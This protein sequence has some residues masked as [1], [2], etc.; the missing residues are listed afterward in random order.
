MQINSIQ[1]GFWDLKS[2][3]GRVGG[4]RFGEASIASSQKTNQAQTLGDMDFIKL[5]ASQIKNQDPT[6]SE[7]NDP[8]KMVDQFIAMGQLQELRSISA[9]LS[10]LQNAQGLALAGQIGSSV[11]VSSDGTCSLGEKPVSGLISLAQ[12][13]ALTLFLTGSDGVEHSIELGMQATGEVPFQLDQKQLQLP[14]GRYDLRVESS[15]GEQPRIEL[16][17]TLESV[18][19]E[20]T[21]QATLRITGLGDQPIERITRFM[22]REKGI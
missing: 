1:P 17:G 12:P 13:G 16:N 22:G 20:H 2:G 19:I 21:G 5:L 11:M 14:K 4:N 8:N 10:M 7:A 6:H 18:N 15:T 3:V 9:R